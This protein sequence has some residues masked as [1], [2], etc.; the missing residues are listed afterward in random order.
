MLKRVEK[1]EEEKITDQENG[2]RANS[3]SYPIKR[4]EIR[5]K[6]IEIDGGYIRNEEGLIK[7][8]EIVGS[9]KRNIQD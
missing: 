6:I 4:I 9:L 1:I 2:E 8:I 5:E 7:V 3:R